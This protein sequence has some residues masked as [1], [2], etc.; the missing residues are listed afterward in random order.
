MQVNF[1]IKEKIMDVSLLFILITI[2]N[3][4]ILPLVFNFKI[5]PNIERKV[6][7]KLKFELFYY[8]LHIFNGYFVRYGEIFLY[9]LTIYLKIPKK[10]NP[11]YALVKVAYSREV[12]STSEIFWS[13]FA[14]FNFV[15]FYIFF[16]IVMN[17]TPHKKLN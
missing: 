10:M 1:M 11:K 13:F 16:I 17:L 8:S 15:F 7:K 2:I 12:F 3:F 9:I 4:L 6:G 14:L 5:I